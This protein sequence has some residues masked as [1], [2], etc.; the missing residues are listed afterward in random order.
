V[1]VKDGRLWDGQ[2][3]GLSR[4]LDLDLTDKVV[5]IIIKLG[6]PKGLILWPV[7]LK[8]NLS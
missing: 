6:L 3:E 2:R 1:F 8:P 7:Y 5:S 4:P